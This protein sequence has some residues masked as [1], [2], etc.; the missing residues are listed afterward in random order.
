MTYVDRPVPLLHMIG[1]YEVAYPRQLMEKTVFESKQ[2]SGPND[3]CLREN[4]A[5]NLLASSLPVVSTQLSR[6]F[7]YIT[8]KVL[9]I[10][11][12]LKASSCLH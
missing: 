4:A 3:G 2:G 5:Y 6:R 9:L 10:E 12:T 1:C 7:H 11:K 8:A